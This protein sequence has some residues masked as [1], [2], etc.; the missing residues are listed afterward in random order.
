MLKNKTLQVT[1]LVG[2][3][4]IF[5]LFIWK[6]PDQYLFFNLVLFKLGLIVFII[7]VIIA[8]IILALIQSSNTKNTKKLEDAYN[9]LF[10]NSIH[11][12]IAFVIVT[13][14]L[15]VGIYLTPIIKR[16]END[17]LSSIIA[18]IITGGTLFI[19]NKRGLKL[20]S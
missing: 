17:S 18:L 14:S 1:L 7:L 16:I 15:S 10:R 4:G 12:L 11:I 6:L 9:K 5:G 20:F 19:L 13:L 8:L 3:V 2:L